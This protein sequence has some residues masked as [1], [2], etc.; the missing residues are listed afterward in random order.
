[1]IGDGL[2]LEVETEMIGGLKKVECRE[3]ESLA[4][5]LEGL[6]GEPAHPAKSEPG[7]GRRAR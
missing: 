5:G 2:G 4:R 3:V 7:F 1:M 6:D